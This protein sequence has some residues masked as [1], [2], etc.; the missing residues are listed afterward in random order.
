[1]DPR[2]KSLALEGNPVHEDMVDAMKALQDKNI[3]AI[4]TVLAKHH[5]VYAAAA[6]DINGSFYEAVEQAKKVFAVKI[7]E[8]A[9]IV[10]TAARFPMDIDL[11][12]SQKALE[13]GKLALKEGGI[14]ILVSECRD[15]TGDDTFIRLL[16]SCST[17]AEVF[18][19]IKKGYVLGYHKAAKLAEINLWA[20]MYAV[21]GLP[22]TV[23]KSIFVKPFH[24]LQAA[25]DEALKKK[26]KNA[27]V[28]FMLDGS[29]TVPT[30]D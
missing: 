30:S 24:S 15:G 4:M 1:M 13:H 19:Q 3:F 22:D 11:Y 2:A 8:K 27:R 10:V 28:L 26:G 20:E 25:L 23:L 16:S 12:Q 5:R 14:L 17:P 6:G 18:N 21:T 9:D 29:L 7:E